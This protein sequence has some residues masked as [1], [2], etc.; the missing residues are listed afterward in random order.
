MRIYLLQAGG[1]ISLIHNTYVELLCQSKLLII[2]SSSPESTDCCY[3]LVFS[4]RRIRRRLVTGPKPKHHSGRNVAFLLAVP[5]PRVGTCR[6]AT[7]RRRRRWKFAPWTHPS[8]QSQWQGGRP[9]QETAAQAQL[10][11]SRDC[12]FRRGREWR[13]AG[14]ATSAS[15]IRSSGRAAG[16]AEGI[17]AYWGPDC[18]TLG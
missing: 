9:T 10:W 5:A 8:H 15:Q 17:T 18:W 6:L 7:C 3:W 16:S 4:H 12:V 13:S 2:V 11:G 1:W 14:C